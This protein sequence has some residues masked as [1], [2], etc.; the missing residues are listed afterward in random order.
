MKTITVSETANYVNVQTHTQLDMDF[1]KEAF[2]A[3][4][5][6]RKVQNHIKASS[7]LIQKSKNV[8]NSKD[9]PCKYFLTTFY[10]KFG[11]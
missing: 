5:L 4:Q 6:W 10:L 11:I 2:R 8:W 1:K 3:N 7:S 9:R